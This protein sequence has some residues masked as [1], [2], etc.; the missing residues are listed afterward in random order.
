MSPLCEGTLV[1]GWLLGCGQGV[2][3]VTMVT[4]IIE[5]ELKV[6]YDIVALH[7]LARNDA[8]V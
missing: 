4:L 8:A 5:M 6:G 1:A 7:L 3:T 2:V